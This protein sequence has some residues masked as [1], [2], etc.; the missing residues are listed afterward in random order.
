MSSHLSPVARIPG[1]GRF[2]PPLGC[3]PACGSATIDLNTGDHLWRIANGDTPENINNHPALQGLAIPNTGKNAH[4]NI[5][6]T[7]TLLF[8]GEGRVR[9]GGRRPVPTG[10]VMQLCC[11]VGNSTDYIAQEKVWP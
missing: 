10:L 5:L 2:V 9:A 11:P 8:Y 1:T 3:W 6:T 7:K 4:A